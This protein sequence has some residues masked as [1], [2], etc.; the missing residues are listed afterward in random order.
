MFSPETHRK[1]KL[2]AVNS[3]RTLIEIIDEAARLWLDAHDPN[4]AK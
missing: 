2:A 1:L 3:D 4:R